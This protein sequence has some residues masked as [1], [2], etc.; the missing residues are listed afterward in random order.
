[1]RAGKPK[2]DIKFQT[3]DYEKIRSGEQPWVNGAGVRAAVRA[4][5]GKKEMI[6]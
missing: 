5:N 2:G 1:M 4:L 6:G 3:P